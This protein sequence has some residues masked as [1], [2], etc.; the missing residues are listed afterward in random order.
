MDISSHNPATQPAARGVEFLQ[1]HRPFSSPGKVRVVWNC[2]GGAAAPWELRTSNVRRLR[3][4]AV[5]GGWNASCVPSAGLTLDTSCELS[6]KDVVSLLSG[7]RH[8]VAQA[9]GAGGCGWELSDSSDRSDGSDEQQPQRLQRWPQ[10]GGPARQLSSAGPFLTVVG[11]G[12]TAANATDHLAAGLFIAN[13]HALG[14]N[15][16][17]PMAPDTALRVE[18]SVL[19][20][21]K[22]EPAQQQ[23]QLLLTT[24]SRNVLLIGG[25][26]HN[27]VTARWHAKAISNHHPNSGGGGGGLALLNERGGVSLADGREFNGAHTVRR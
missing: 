22:Q 18:G 21:S 23:Q 13:S 9:Q 19:S 20:S 5:A 6:Q 7:R 16:H 14:Y 27:A 8:L 1:L 4:Y 26:K 15:T 12:G 2:K 11:T 3:L 25:V 10:A 24:L 17:A